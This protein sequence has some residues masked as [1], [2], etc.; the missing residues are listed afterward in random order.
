MT[1][2]LSIFKEP[3]G[4]IRVIQAIMAI[5]AFSTTAGF[6]TSVSFIMDCNSDDIHDIEYHFGY[7][8]SLREIP[9]TIPNCNET[10]SHRVVYFPYVFSGS[11]EFFV[12]T[13]VI[14]F[15][16]T[17]LISVVYTIGQDTYQ[18]NPM[19]PLVDMG[20][21]SVIT[22]FWLAGSSAWA[23]SVSDMKYYTKPEN[24][25]KNLCECMRKDVCKS[26]DMGSFASLDVSLVFGFSNFLL[27]GVSIW[28]VYKETTF[29]QQR[30]QQQGQTNSAGKV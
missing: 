1:T 24:L 9:L 8:F 21:T 13:G 17:I 26:D 22:L 7:P 12:A 27:W 18:N 10:G 4:F 2:N 6:S 28:F 15:L 16:Y 20:I 30:Q 23:D 3:R 14:A 25:F 5:F 29:H 11:A 19:Y